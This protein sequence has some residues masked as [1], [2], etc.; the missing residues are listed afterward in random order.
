MLLLETEP[1]LGGCG[2]TRERFDD[3]WF[4][5]E[6]GGQSLWTLDGRA[7][8]HT[9]TNKERGCGCRGKKV[10]PAGR[11]QLSSRKRHLGQLICLLGS[12]TVNSV[13]LRPVRWRVIDTHQEKGSGPGPDGC[14]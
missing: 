4:L 6:R 7:R 8:T 12:A 3:S 11:E 13:E 10:R 2:R 5:Q 14:A 9:Q 1:L